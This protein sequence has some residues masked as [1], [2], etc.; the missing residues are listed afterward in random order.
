MNQNGNNGNGNLGNT[1]NLSSSKKRV[2]PSKKWALTLFNYKMETVIQRFQDVSSKGVIGVEICPETGREHLQCY[3][4]F[5][6]KVRANETYKLLKGH[7][8]KAKGSDSE[9][10]RYCSKDGK[11]KSWGHFNTLIEHYKINKDDLTREQ[12]YI[13]DKFNEKEDPKFGRK[14]YWYWEAKGGWG[15]SLLATYMVDNMNGIMVSGAKKDVLFGVS[16]MV[17][18]GR[19]PELVVVD[20]PR[21]NKDAV[22][23]Q[24][25]EMIKN[26]MFYNEKYESGMCRFPRPH[27][28]CFSNH[29]PPLQKMSRDR[30]VVVKLDWTDTWVEVMEELET[31]RLSPPLQ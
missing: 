5:N 3:I 19:D 7:W 10:Y 20:I 13:A 14:I 21:V 12:V 29:P 9:N 25:I 18:K 27:I 22:S 4:V 15:K 28:V 6:N 17:E 31:L 8:E 16:Q 2:I 11:F 26:G 30:W 24:A 23:V 1:S